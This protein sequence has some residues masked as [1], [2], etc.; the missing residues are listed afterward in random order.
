MSFCSFMWSRWPPILSPFWKELNK[1]NLAFC[2]CTEITCFHNIF[3]SFVKPLDIKEYFAVILFWRSC[4]AEAVV[5]FLCW[6]LYLVC[7]VTL[8]YYLLAGVRK[9]GSLSWWLHSGA[10]H[11]FCFSYDFVLVGI[12]SKEFDLESINR[13]DHGH[14]HNTWKGPCSQLKSAGAGQFNG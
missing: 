13:M 5:L 2:L 14:R 10:Q 11:G 8:H 7:I 6:F 4:S 1:N 3:G 9:N 12:Q